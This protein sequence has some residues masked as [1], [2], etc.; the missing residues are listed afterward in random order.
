MKKIFDYMKQPAFWLVFCSLLML[1][2][3]TIVWE[4]LDT[5]DQEAIKQYVKDNTPAD[6]QFSENRA[7][8]K[9][10]VLQFTDL[11]R[12]PGRFELYYNDA[13]PFR[14]Y[15]VWKSR[16]ITTRLTNNFNPKIIEGKD[17]FLFYTVPG[18]PNNNEAYD[19]TGK[20]QWTQAQMDVL[21]SKLDGVRKGLAE[22]GIH[23]CVVIAPNKMTVYPEK[24]PEKRHY[25]RAEQLRAEQ[26]VA[27][28]KQHAPELQ[29]RFLEVPLRDA[30]KNVD[31][32]LFFQEDTHWNALAGYIS[33]REILKMIPGG[34]Q[35]PPLWEAEIVPAGNM[36]GGDLRNQLGT[37]TKGT[38]PIYRVKLP[39]EKKIRILP[40]HSEERHRWSDN[41][42]AP[43]Q[44]TIWFYRDSF[45]DAVLPYLTQI[46]RRTDSYHRNVPIRRSQFANPEKRPHIVVFQIVERNLRSLDSVDF[47]SD[48][49]ERLELFR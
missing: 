27:Y 25:K 35:L 32:P 42:S 20:K 48:E 44:R 11:Q 34:K 31:F 1:V 9:K 6:Q 28:A 7:A 33:A 36:V 2:V 38:Y 41:P 5:E 14:D 45:G 23:F 4:D 30:K 21:V 37:G 15:L 16:K 49:D 43:D 47:E 46:F 29:I 39:G 8:V 40:E 17:G 12:Y 13:F 24:L 18:S 10:P 19:F 3:P 26:L 22:M